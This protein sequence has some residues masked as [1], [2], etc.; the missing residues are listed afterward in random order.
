MH[1]FIKQYRRCLI[2]AMIMI[3]L[4]WTGL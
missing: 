2:T 4:F 1:R 3:D